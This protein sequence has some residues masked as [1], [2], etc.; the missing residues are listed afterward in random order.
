MY[1]SWGKYSKDFG[2]ISHWFKELIPLYACMVDGL[3]GRKSGYVEGV[4]FYHQD[5]RMAK[6]RKD[7]FEWFGGR[8]H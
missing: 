2:A 3:E 6:L 5:G 8:R 4:V 7:M 1:K